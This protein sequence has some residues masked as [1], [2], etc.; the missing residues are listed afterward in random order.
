LR[1][2]GVPEQELAKIR[3]MTLEPS[4]NITVLTA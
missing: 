1:Q 4:G 3:R 2:N